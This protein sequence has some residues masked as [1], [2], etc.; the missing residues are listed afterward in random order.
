MVD[1]LAVA[2][3]AIVGFIA[4]TIAQCHH[5]QEWSG[6]SS[7]I[8]IVASAVAMIATGLITHRINNGR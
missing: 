3:T 4:I 6:A 1:W 5:I 7:A 2:S 8:Y